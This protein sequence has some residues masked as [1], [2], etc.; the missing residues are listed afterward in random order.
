MPRKLQL[1]E[2][3]PKLTQQALA[4]RP[5]F[6]ITCCGKLMCQTE[7][8]SYQADETFSFDRS[9]VVLRCSDCRRSVC[10]EFT[11]RDVGREVLVEHVNK[12][13]PDAY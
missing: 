2:L 12:G 13:M 4:T 9:V 10:A 1:M 3:P 5:L 8:Y 11:V 6:R 7:V